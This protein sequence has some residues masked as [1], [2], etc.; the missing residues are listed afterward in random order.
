MTTRDPYVLLGVA[1][2]ATAVEIKAAWRAKMREMHPDLGGDHDESIA[3]QAAYELLADPER[4]AEFDAG[5]AEREAQERR[6]QERLRS[7]R[8]R[9]QRA[10]QQ[11]QARA[12]DRAERGAGGMDLVGARAGD[13]TAPAV[14]VPSRGAVFEGWFRPK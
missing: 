5:V 12:D 7:D 11:K 10:E 6:Y 13:R 1:S 2:N 4:R 14:T 9:R 8:E 3:L